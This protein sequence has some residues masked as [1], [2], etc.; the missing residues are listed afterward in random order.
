MEPMEETIVQPDGIAGTEKKKRGRPKGSRPLCEKG[1]LAKYPDPKVVIWGI[2]PACKRFKRKGLA[3][4]Y[5]PDHPGGCVTLMP[6][7]DDGGEGMRWRYRFIPGPMP[8]HYEKI[9]LEPGQVASLPAKLRELADTLDGVVKQNFGDIRGADKTTED[10]HKSVKDD[11]LS[12]KI[13]K[14]GMV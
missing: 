4:L 2:E 6:V 11:E 5:N 10:Y 14:L 13:K 9:D 8:Y 3:I 12:A 1:E 7:T